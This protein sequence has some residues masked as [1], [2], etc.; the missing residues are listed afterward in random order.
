MSTVS[1]E[2]EPAIAEITE[3]VVS[4]VILLVEFRHCRRTESSSSSRVRPRPLDEDPR[5]RKSRRGFRMDLRLMLETPV[6]V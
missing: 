5:E 4:G 2:V 3:H 1:N 6:L